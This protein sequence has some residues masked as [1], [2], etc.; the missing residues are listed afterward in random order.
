MLKKNLYTKPHQII[1]LNNSSLNITIL[2]KQL[3]FYVFTDIMQKRFW[4]FISK[5]TKKLLG[6][7]NLLKFQKKFKW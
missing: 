6:K 1:L 7:I 3:I 5:N 4:I 2:G